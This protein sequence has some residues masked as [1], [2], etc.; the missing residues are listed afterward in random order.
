MATWIASGVRSRWAARGRAA[1]STACRSNGIARNAGERSGSCTSTSTRVAKEVARRS[2]VLLEHSFRSCILISVMTKA[3][4]RLLNP[5]I[6]RLPVGLSGVLLAG[7]V[8]FAPSAFPQPSLSSTVAA[9]D[10]VK[11]C[12]AAGEADRQE[13]AL[14]SQRRSLALD[15]AL[16]SESAFW[17]FF[18]DPSTSYLDRMA[19]A[20]QGGRLIPAEQ[21]I[22][23]WKASAEFEVLPTGV[24]PSPASLWVT[25]GRREARR[26][27]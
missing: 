22:R 7:L 1:S 16:Q 25:H 20:Y 2:P 6:S 9:D 3:S 14:T 11:T 17:K 23:L 15:T 4:V 26:R 10:P 19:A 8:A 24:N 27:G 13:R 5:A 21:L 12:P 18:I